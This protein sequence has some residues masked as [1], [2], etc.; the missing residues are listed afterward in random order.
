MEQ[1]QTLK[2][3][4]LYIHVVGNGQWGNS[5]YVTFNREGDSNPIAAGVSTAGANLIINASTDSYLLDYYDENDTFVDIRD[6][7]FYIEIFTDGSKTIEPKALQVRLR[8]IVQDNI[9]WSEE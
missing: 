7:K 5:S 1:Q 2:A 3:F 6:D 9:V 8:F 4:E